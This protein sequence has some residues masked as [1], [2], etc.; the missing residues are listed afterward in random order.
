MSITSDTSASSLPAR[1]DLR[2][3][4]A[5]A[6]GGAGVALLVDGGTFARWYDSESMSDAGISSGELH[7]ELGAGSWAGPDGLISDIATYLIAPGDTV[8]LRQNLTL[9]AFGSDMDATFDLDAS[10]MTGDP[11]L[12]RPGHHDV[13][14]D[15]AERYDCRRPER[16]PRVRDAR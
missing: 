10:Q 11:A 5:I 15:A 8:T 13:D 4:M 7:F 14:P 1:R 9:T 12:R 3:F 2:L 16:I 6:I